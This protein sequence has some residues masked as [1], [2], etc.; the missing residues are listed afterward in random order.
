M[1]STLKYL[2]AIVLGGA[3]ALTLGQSLDPGQLLNPLQ[4]PGP[5][6]RATIRVADTAR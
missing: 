5:P 6:I 2:F 1:K 3:H 4:I